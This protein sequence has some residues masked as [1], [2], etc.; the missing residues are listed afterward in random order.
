MSKKQILNR[1]KK[2]LATELTALKS[3]SKTINDNFFKVVSKSDFKTLPS[4][5]KSCLSSD[6]FPVKNSIDLNG[7]KK[8]YDK[9]TEVYV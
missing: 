1:A 2:T 4:V 3:L 6:E 8:S 9:I 5:I 7:V